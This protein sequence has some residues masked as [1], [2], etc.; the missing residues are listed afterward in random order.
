MTSKPIKSLEFKRKCLNLHRFFDTYE[1]VLIT[2]Q[3]IN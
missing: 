2:K 3:F 1:K